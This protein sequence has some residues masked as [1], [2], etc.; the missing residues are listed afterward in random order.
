MVLV[1]AQCVGAFGFPVFVRG[2]E[3]LR[4]CGCKA[5]ERSAACCCGTGECCAG[6]PKEAKAE[7]PLCPKCRTKQ[8]AEPAPVVSVTIVKAGHC[9][10]ES[11][12]VAGLSVENPAVPP[13]APAKPAFAPAPAGSVCQVDLSATS[14]VCLPPDPPP[15]RR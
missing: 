15:R 13:S 11:D 9:H 1:L 5:S 2:G 4:P 14:T 10:G 3:A 12:S 6:G 8:P 7:P